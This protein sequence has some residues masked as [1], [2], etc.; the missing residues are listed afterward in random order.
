MSKLDTLTAAINTRITTGLAALNNAAD[1]P[2]TT[3]ITVLTE[4]A[5]DLQTKIDKAINELGLLVLIG[6]PHFVN[7]ELLANS[8]NC[9]ISLAVAVGE[10]P[11]L[12]R[13]EAE[14]KPHCV[15]VMEYV[16]QLLTQ[17]RVAGFQ[18]LRVLR[19]DFVPDKKR[20][21]YEISLETMFLLPK[22]P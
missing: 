20:Q 13:D 11:T 17:F 4:D 8:A 15:A 1:G 2:L 14:L 10:N 19:A 6:Q 12:W 21:A 9:K 16:V 3:E 22:I 18:N 7:T 5:G